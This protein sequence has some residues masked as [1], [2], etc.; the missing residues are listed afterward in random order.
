MYA[1]IQTVCGCHGFL[2]FE[3]IHCDRCRSLIPFQL[4]EESLIDPVLTN[5]MINGVNVKPMPTNKQA[6]NM[7]VSHQ[8]QHGITIGHVRFRALCPFCNSPTYVLRYFCK[9]ERM[10]YHLRVQYFGE[11]EHTVYK[12]IAEI[13]NMN[14]HEKD[15]TSRNQTNSSMSISADDS[16]TLSGTLSQQPPSTIIY[17]QTGL[18]SA[19]DQQIKNEKNLY[20]FQD[21]EGDLF[22]V[23]RNGLF[24]DTILQCQDGVKIQAHRCILGGRS[25]WFRNLLGEHHD[26]ETKGD[27][28]LQISID[29]VQSE[30]MNE[31]LNFIYTNRCLISLK[32]APDLLIVAKRF[33]LEKLSRQVSDFLI[34]RLNVDN[35]LDMLISAHES[36][37]DALK[38]AC[39]RLINRHAEKIKR[40]EKWKKFKAEYVDLVPE[41]YENRIERPPHPQHTFLPDVFTAPAILPESI[42]KLSQLYDN[43]VKQRAPSPKSRILPPPKQRQKPVHQNPSFQPVQH[44]HPKE[45]MIK[46]TTGPFPP[47]NGSTLSSAFGR[48]SPVRKQVANNTG[49]RPAPPQAAVPTLTRTVFPNAKQ[50]P[51]VEAYRRPVNVYDKSVAVPTNNQKQKPNNNQ[52]SRRSPPS[53]PIKA[54]KPISPKR[55]IEIR[56]SPTLTD[57]SQDEQLTLARV[58]SVDTME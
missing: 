58:I 15:D 34:F 24:Y 50:Q 28:V 23:L 5:N 4:S 32:N 27:Y 21:I 52:V 22:D 51:Q 26:L 25:H 44:A 20:P 19:R 48:E 2:L 42:H 16:I 45:L 8:K 1:S 14:N 43:P 10:Y 17:D 37:S 33:E 3:S 31:I 56:R 12:S 54:S 9:R 46:E 47:R 29:D 13:Q 36:D 41:L 40:T 38:H 30:I 55:V 57:T 35:A 39:I 49:R 7:L 53:A 6:S 11:N 18:Q